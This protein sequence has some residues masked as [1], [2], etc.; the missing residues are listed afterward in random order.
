MTRRPTLPTP[1]AGGGRVCEPYG[2]EEAFCE[3]AVDALADSLVADDDEA[4]RVVGEVIDETS[5]KIK[6]IHV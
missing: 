4:A 3:L 2:P 6:D 5:T 1:A